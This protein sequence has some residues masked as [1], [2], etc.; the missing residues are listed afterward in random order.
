[1][2]YQ[3]LAY[4][5]AIKIIQMGKAFVDDTDQETMKEER[6]AMK[7]SKCRKLSVEEN[8]KRFEE[9]RQA[10]ELGLKCCL[11]I[12]QPTSPESTFATKDY[13][14]TAADRE[15]ITPSVTQRKHVGHMSRQD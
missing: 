2:L 7:H 4:E 9:M 3:F 11:R 12:G 10:T 14:S 13:C 5:Y 1:M 8:L 15:R 6:T